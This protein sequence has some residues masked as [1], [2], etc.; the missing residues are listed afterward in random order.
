V[1]YVVDDDWKA[2]SVNVNSGNPWFAV[3]VHEN[4]TTD[5]VEVLTLNYADSGGFW[6]YDYNVRLAKIW[7][8]L[9]YKAS[10]LSESK[11]EIRLIHLVEA[12]MVYGELTDAASSKVTEFCHI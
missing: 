1:G 3:G 8:Y 2:R 11:P 9:S 4:A 5:V 6:S 10:E 12:H 7:A